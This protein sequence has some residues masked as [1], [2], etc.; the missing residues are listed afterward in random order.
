MSKQPTKK[1]ASRSIQSPLIIPFRINPIVF[2]CLR[3]ICESNFCYNF[4]ADNRLSWPIVCKCHLQRI[5]TAKR[6]LLLRLMLILLIARYL[7]LFRCVV[8]FRSPLCRCCIRWCFILF[9]CAASSLR[10]FG[11]STIENT[12]AAR[13]PGNF[14]FARTRYTRRIIRVRPGICAAIAHTHRVAPAL[15]AFY[16]ALSAATMKQDGRSEGGRAGG[17]TGVVCERVRLPA[18]MFEPKCVCAR[19]ECELCAQCT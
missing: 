3:R 14:A 11:C 19:E 18:R 2:R 13:Q 6:L 8:L 4:L 9:N 15:R 10:P 17:R 7:S 5:T 16:F 12:P 1:T